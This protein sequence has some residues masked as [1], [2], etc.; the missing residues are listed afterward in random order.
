[1]KSI[2][3]RVA[4]AIHDQRNWYETANQEQT[5]DEVLILACR[6]MVLAELTGGGLPPLFKGE[7][8]LKMAQIVIH[9]V[10]S[11][12]ELAKATVDDEER[13]H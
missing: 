6:L 9:A 12:E 5:T 4:R 7:S 2:S 1:M 3:M 10:P 11:E 8:A 13:V